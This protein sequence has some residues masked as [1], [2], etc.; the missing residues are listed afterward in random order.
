MGLVA[1]E[2][3][4][5]VPDVVC[6]VVLGGGDGRVDS[7]GGGGDWQGWWVVRVCFG[8]LTVW[9]IGGFL[10]VVAIA[11]WAGSYITF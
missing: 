4:I 7:S 8:Y 5:S 6:L 11:R 9:G 3:L 2:Q 1:D 10:V